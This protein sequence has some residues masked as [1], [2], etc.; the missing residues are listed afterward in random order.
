[1]PTPDQ[2]NR[3]NPRRRRLDEVIGAFLIALDAGQNPNPREWLAQPELCPELAEYV[4]R[5]SHR[6]HAQGCRLSD[7]R[8]RKPGQQNR[9]HRQQRQQRDFGRPPP[10]SRSVFRWCSQAQYVA[11]RS[12]RMQD[13]LPQVGRHAPALGRRHHSASRPANRAPRTGSWDPAH[14]KMIFTAG[15]HPQ[16]RLWDTATCR[17]VGPVLVH[18]AREPSP[19][20]GVAAI[21]PDGLS[22]ATVSNEYA[23]TPRVPQSTARLSRS[24]AGG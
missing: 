5:Q 14:M 9:S 21:S 3:D 20:P 24:L 13:L 2:P 10:A 22:I 18:P 6:Q 15:P 23:W 4:H 19:L 11:L 1:M 17:H 12:A 7:V 8:G 16:V